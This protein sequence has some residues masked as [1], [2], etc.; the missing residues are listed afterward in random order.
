[1]MSSIEYDALKYVAEYMSKGLHPN[2]F[3][4]Y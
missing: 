4:Y 3:F 1:M 2:K